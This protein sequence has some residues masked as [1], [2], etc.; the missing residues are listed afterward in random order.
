MSS[1]PGHSESSVDAVKIRWES[2]NGRFGDLTYTVTHPEDVPAPG[3]GR[4]LRT[5]VGKKVP[6]R[7]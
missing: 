3:Y 2:W 4:T 5:R 6:K 7:H 1:S